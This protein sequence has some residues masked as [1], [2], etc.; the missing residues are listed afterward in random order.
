[1][2]SHEIDTINF[3]GSKTDR[4]HRIKIYDEVIQLI[5]GVCGIARERFF[6]F[7]EEDDAALS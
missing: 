4:D 2:T 3:P 7:Q 1:M 5:R 6:G